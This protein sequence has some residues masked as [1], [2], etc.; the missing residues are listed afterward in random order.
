VSPID[1]VCGADS[2]PASHMVLGPPEDVSILGSAGIN[3][4]LTKM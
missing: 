2:Q 4:E 1:I 3:Y